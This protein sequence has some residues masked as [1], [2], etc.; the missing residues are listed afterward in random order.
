MDVESFRAVVGRVDLPAYVELNLTA[1]SKISSIL[2]E[3]VMYALNGQMTPEE[4]LTEAAKL[5]N[6]EIAK[7]Q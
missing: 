7:E 1:Y 6:E 3:Y 2:N 4:A 5:A